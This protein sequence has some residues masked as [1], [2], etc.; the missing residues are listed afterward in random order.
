MERLSAEVLYRFSQLHRGTFMDSES[1]R[2]GIV[3]NNW[4][5]NVCHMH[6][7]LVSAARFETQPH[8]G[9]AFETL[10]KGI[11]GARLFTIGYHRHFG[12]LTWVTAYGLID[13]PAAGHYAIY[14]RLV[15]S[16]NGSGLQLRH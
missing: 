3:A 11:M 6:T 10:Y 15:L 5:T 4:K 7:N 8:M 2:I 12:A 14:N 9:M 1:P 16:L 13:Y